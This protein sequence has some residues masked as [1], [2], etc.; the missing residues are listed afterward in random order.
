MKISQKDSRLGILTRGLSRY[1]WTAG[2]KKREARETDRLGVDTGAHASSVSYYECSYLL[3]VEETQSRGATAY[4]YCGQNVES[5]RKM[6]T[7]KYG[8]C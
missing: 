8:L 2:S 5:S 6:D 3:L 1:S 4:S 7:M